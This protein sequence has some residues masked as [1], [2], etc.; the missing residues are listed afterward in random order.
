M[1]LA[2]SHRVSDCWS[3][4]RGSR[5]LR[6]L[7]V[8]DKL[9]GGLTR[10][11]C[12]EPGQS[13]AAERSWSA[14]AGE[15]QWDR[16]P[17]QTGGNTPKQRRQTEGV[18]GRAALMTAL[19]LRRENYRAAAGWLLMPASRRFSVI[20]SQQLLYFPP[21]RAAGPPGPLANLDPWL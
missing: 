18:E 7:S 12:V 13:A 9:Q 1:P 17:Q 16:Q 11:W 5:L 19:S 21:Y 4:L 8:C 3:G 14:A 20:S 2:T 10:F 6:R 15:L